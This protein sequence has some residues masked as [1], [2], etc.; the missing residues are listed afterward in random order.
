MSSSPKK[1]ILRTLADAT[2]AGYLPLS[3]IVSDDAIGLLGLDGRLVSFSLDQVRWVCFVRDFNPGDA[4]QPERLTR[5]AF[6]ARPR[7]EGLWVRLTLRG[8]DPLEGLAPTDL[9][10]LDSLLTDRGLYLTPPDIRS[11]TQRVFVPHAAIVEIQLLA[12]ITTP[13]RPKPPADASG[14]LFPSDEPAA[15]KPPLQSRL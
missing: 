7:A 3:C 5:R 6:L 4:V 15:A 11:N 14:D 10:L 8:G 13:S 12:V 9:S 1:V 2:H